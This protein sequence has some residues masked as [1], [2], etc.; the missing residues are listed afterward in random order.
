[1]VFS[2][3]TRTDEVRWNSPISCQNAHKINIGTNISAK[4]LIFVAP[5]ADL[6]HRNE[7]FQP[8][9]LVLAPLLVGQR[10]EHLS[11]LTT[12]L[13]ALHGGPCQMLNGSRR[14]RMRTASWRSC[15]PSRCWMPQRW[16]NFWHKMVGPVVNREAVAHLRAKLGL[17]EQ[18]AA[19]SSTR[20]GRRSN[21]NRAAGASFRN[22]QHSWK[23]V[24]KALCNAI[25]STKRGDNGERR[26]NAYLRC[27]TACFYPPEIEPVP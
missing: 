13:S 17:S 10:A 26:R 11:H 18:Q 2:P 25:S 9:R 15:W 20:I 4:Y 19:K 23:C 6:S 5:G 22:W 1:M 7:D 3:V 12:L 27:H 14:W 16:K 8:H 21:I 24:E